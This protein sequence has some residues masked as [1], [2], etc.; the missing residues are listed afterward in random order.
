MNPD[1]EQLLAYA[2]GQLSPAE[3]AQV[4]A[5]IDADPELRAEVQADRDA[6]LA[7]VETLD[8]AAAE[9]PPGAQERLLARL[10]AET[11][12]VS[13]PAPGAPL[14]TVPGRPVA[15]S[16]ST[17]PLWTAAAL[18]AALAVGLWL[19]PPADSLA[20]YA[21]VPGAAAQA[22]GPAG[23]P[24]GNLVR[25]PD[26]RVYVRLGQAPA[27]GRT[28]QLWRI[29]PGGAPVSL[30]VFGRDVLTASLPQGTS[31]AVSVEPPG[32]SP[33]PT[34]TPLFVQAL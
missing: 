20:R 1:R 12:P 13:G 11:A 16:R 29:A 23:A 31:V 18:A 22:L 8:L 19:R 6:L 33:Q 27:Q 14:R 3:A 28:Y 4:Q 25:L 10:R 30:G 9:V 15:R 17:T 26:G 21:A 24:L 32:G 34:T 2:L 5:R 7:L